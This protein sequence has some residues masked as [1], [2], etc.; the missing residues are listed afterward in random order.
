MMNRQIDARKV[1]GS[2]QLH[3]NRLRVAMSK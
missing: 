1:S 3:S 2:G